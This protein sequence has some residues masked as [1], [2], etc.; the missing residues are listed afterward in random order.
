MRTFPVIAMIDQRDVK[1]LNYIPWAADDGTTNW[2]VTLSDPKRGDD[3][4]DPGTARIVD[5]MEYQI[6]NGGTRVDGQGA[7]FGYDEKFPY[8]NAVAEVPGVFR[9]EQTGVPFVSGGYW[10]LRGTAVLQN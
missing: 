8:T 6:D 2:S 4:R 9:I 10:I 3:K 5:T 7:L 1:T